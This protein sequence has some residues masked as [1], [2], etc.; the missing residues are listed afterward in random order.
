MKIAITILFFFVCL[1]TCP[2]YLMADDKPV[3][4]EDKSLDEISDIL[5]KKLK[6][7]ND[8]KKEDQKKQEPEAPVIYKY[9]DEKGQWHF[10]SDIHM[11]PPRYQKS[12]IEI[13]G[14]N[15]TDAPARSQESQYDTQYDPYSSMKKIEAEKE[16]E[17]QKWR[18]QWLMLKDD[19]EQKKINYE[20]LKNTPPDCSMNYMKY[21]VPMTGNCEEN[22]KRTVKKA[23]SEME[24]AE[25]RL[26]RFRKEARRAGIA[27]GYLR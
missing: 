11:I 9:Q 24:Q 4:T 8:S 3:S 12:V 6:E 14:S 15:K 18:K 17:G 5:K 7:Q 13:M 21:G 10:S 22:W 26:E 23:K 19:Y 20:F 2:L 25:E 1:L 27:P 16:A